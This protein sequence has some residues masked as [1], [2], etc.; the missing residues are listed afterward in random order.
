MDAMMKVCGKS[1]SN[2]A[3]A[4]AVD[5]NGVALY[6]HVWETEVT[7]VVNTQVSDALAHTYPETSTNINVGDFA[8]I[9]L[10]VRNRHNQSVTITIN[11]AGNG[12]LNSTGDR[13]QLVVPA[14]SQVLIT[15]DDFPCLNVL[16]G[17]QIKY[18]YSVAPTDA[19]S[20]DKLEIW[21]IKKR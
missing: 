10:K 3:K 7:K 13:Y 12:I 11:D 5:A 2:T 8:L 21:V 20:S 4:F 1:P 9:S 6:K 14:E 17:F 15:A 16:D 18:Q 19:T